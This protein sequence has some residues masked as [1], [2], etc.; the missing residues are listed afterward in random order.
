MQQNH[1]NEWISTLFPEAR[2]PYGRIPL[3]LLALCGRMGR[4][5]LLDFLTVFSLMHFA[6]AIYQR[7]CQFKVVHEEDEDG[8]RRGK[9]V[10]RS[11]NDP[12]RFQ[13]ALPPSPP[14]GFDKGSPQHRA[15][16]AAMAY[17]GYQD[18]NI[19]YFRDVDHQTRQFLR[20][21]DLE[22][23]QPYFD[24]P[25]ELLDPERNRD[26]RREDY[27]VL[28]AVNSCIG[29]RSYWQITRQMI[30][31]RT[32]G[33]KDEKRPVWMGRPLTE[34]QVEY[35]LG[36][37]QAKGFIHRVLVAKRFTFIGNPK[38]LD[39]DDL[40]AIAKKWKRKRKTAGRATRA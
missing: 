31:S 38:R 14:A 34:R 15:I 24:V 7:Q 36:K 8:I 27:L 28:F 32:A 30:A 18:G 35:S 16:G 21:N 29:E 4:D 9:L 33:A 10:K 25:C 1:F 22:Q 2:T 40:I 6:R 19:D 3:P 12:P 37:L 5:A 13:L 20:E 17:M 23:G 11:A 39:L 26:L